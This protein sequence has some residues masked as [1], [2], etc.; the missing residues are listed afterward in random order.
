MRLYK[1]LLVLFV[2]ASSART[3][4]EL[5]IE[6]VKCVCQSVAYAYRYKRL[7]ESKF[8]VRQDLLCMSH[9]WE[10]L[11]LQSKCFCYGW[12][13]Y[14][15]NKIITTQGLE[16]KMDSNPFILPHG[17]ERKASE[18]LTPDPAVI[19]EVVDVFAS[20]LRKQGKHRVA[21]IVLD[22]FE[23]WPKKVEVTE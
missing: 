20:E 17:E 16:T 22:T 13:V 5:N 11:S 6:N 2:L 15:V 21:N 3:P 19:R 8:I 23:T 9:L 1:I 10:R 7:P 18:T 14:M 12:A 4:S